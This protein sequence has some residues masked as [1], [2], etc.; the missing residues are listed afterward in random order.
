[1]T[2][3]G[4]TLFLAVLHGQSAG[5]ATGLHI[6]GRAV[7]GFKTRDGPHNSERL[8]RPK[9]TD[10]DHTK[11]EVGLTKSMHTERTQTYGSTARRHHN[12]RTARVP[13]P[14]P[15]SSED[16]IG[17]AQL[18][19]LCHDP[20]GRPLCWLWVNK[21][22]VLAIIDTGA[23]CCAIKLP[24]VPHLKGFQL[25]DTCH[26]VHGVG[27]G[28]VR[29]VGGATLTIVLPDKY[30][31]LHRMLVIDGPMPFPGTTLIGIDLLRKFNW[32]MVSYIKPRESHY[33]MLNGHKIPLFYDNGGY[34]E[35]PVNPV[36]QPVTDPL[37]VNTLATEPASFVVRSARAKTCPPQTG[38][39]IPVQPIPE[40]QSSTVL[41]TD[42]DAEVTVPSA[43]LQSLSHVWVINL[44]LMPV[45]VAAGT[46]IALAETGI[47]EVDE[48]SSVTP[49]D[50]L[51]VDG[52]PTLA[53]ASTQLGLETDEDGC[54]EESVHEVV[55]EEVPASSKGHDLAHLTSQQ[56]QQVEALIQQFPELFKENAP[57]GIVPGIKHQI[58]TEPGAI[59][60]RTKQ[61]RMPETSRS[62]IRRQ[63]DEMLDMGVIEPSTSPWLS[64]VVLVRKKDGKLRFCVDFRKINALTMMDSWPMPRIDELI[65]DLGGAIWFTT[66]DAKNAYWTIE[67]D[68]EDKDKTAFSDGHRLLQF[69]RM[70]FGLV[71]APSTFMRAM[72]RI[73]SPVLGRHTLAYL[74]DVVIFSATFED[75]LKHLAETLTLLQA[76]EFRLNRA[77]CTLAAPEIKFLGFQ[78]NKDGVAPDPGK[79]AAIRD[80]PTPQ[81]PKAVRRFLGCTGFYRRHVPDYAALAHPLFRL[82]RK[83]SLFTWGQEEQESFETLKQK[84]ITA[85]I[86]RLPDFSLEFEIHCDAS[87]IAIGACLMQQDPSEQRPY[88]ISYYSRKLKGAEERYAPI[89]LEALAVVEAVRHFDP[90]VYGRHFVIYTDHRPLTYVF[91]R[92]CS[93]LRM[94]RWWHEMTLYSYTLKYKK[95]AVNYIP[96]ALSRDVQAYHLYPIE[97]ENEREGSQASVEDPL[98]VAK[99]AAAQAEDEAWRT[100]L[101]Y[102]RD[103]PVP[104]HGPRRYKDMDLIDGCIYVNTVT[105]TGETVAQMVIPKA[106]RWHAIRRAHD[107][108]T[109]GHQG[110][111]STLQRLKTLYYF[112]GMQ[113]AVKTYVAGC[114]T[115]QEIR[116]QVCG[117]SPLAH[118]P[119]PT[120]PFDR[121][122]AD[123]LII[124]TA[125]STVKNRYTVCLT[126]IDHYTRYCILVPLIDKKKD[127]CARTMVD[128][129]FMPFGPPNTV[130]LDHGSEF[131]NRT[132]QDLCL[133]LG[134]KVNFTII[135]R[136]QSNGIIERTHRVIREMLNALTPEAESGVWQNYVPYIQLIMNTSV[137]TSLQDTPLH[138]LTGRHTYFPLGDTNRVVYCPEQERVVRLADLKRI[139]GIA[140]EVMARNRAKWKANH[141]ERFVRKPSR[142][143]KVGDL[144]MRHLRQAASDHVAS[145]WMRKWE[146][147]YRIEAQKG[148]LA[149]YI[150]QLHGR[151]EA[152]V[153]AQN[154]KP[155]FY[156]ADVVPPG[157][158][159]VNVRGTEVDDDVEGVDVDDPEPMR[160]DEGEDELTRA[161]EDTREESDEEDDVPLVERHRRQRLAERQEIE[162]TASTDDMPPLEEERT[163]DTVTWQP[164]PCSDPPARPQGAGGRTAIGEEFELS[165]EQGV[166][167]APPPPPKRDYSIYP[168][169]QSRY[170]ASEPSARTLRSREPKPGTSKE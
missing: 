117:R 30:T 100:V 54:D 42:I 86:L 102:L 170:R 135:R 50:L 98:S 15:L 70:P 149:F 166:E 31:F 40:L 67:M 10:H 19:S 88:P 18:W 51:E 76:A 16:T 115:C 41:V 144:V 136:P 72:A 53:C 55:E 52:A 49:V 26:S 43:Y 162:R 122:S 48:S 22:K 155:F 146:G 154:M 92:R 131:F 4:T 147:P 1:M 20:K 13:A 75:H 94:N 80:M 99:V 74:D 71:T 111:Q 161:S 132:L 7:P 69:T 23:E 79:I 66:L 37:H 25:H 141:D 163:E 123:L 24:L 89:D 113:L 128:R 109:A 38:I 139:R 150:K 12:K 112:P 46:P 5:S 142:Q 62:E 68:P 21:F 127:L 121:I 58:R 60:I 45:T 159:V 84:L 138:L 47:T 151:K 65:D 36:K 96:D 104:I 95:G 78:I 152:T 64:P 97:E 157:N 169:H 133:T 116:G 105:P 59:P 6:H 101:E 140:Q 73:L 156:P 130:Q 124:T 106:L 126:V 85:P 32:R 160:D 153:H 81:S 77:K 34:S 93:N 118:Q 63:C 165:E 134:I 120:G 3:H 110:W 9:V 87:A 137:H 27:D 148:P 82:T 35:D 14:V 145:S 125:K 61:W 103:G 39:W 107:H 8:P 90:Y 28:P 33:L 83:D 167:L 158:V 29:V 164:V 168:S 56:A 119:D 17:P 11:M 44:S 91:H 108:V 143:F 114:Q 57:L 2:V 129:V